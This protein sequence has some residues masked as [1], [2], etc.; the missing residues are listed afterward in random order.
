MVGELHRGRDESAGRRAG[1]VWVGVGM[2]GFPR[3]REFTG[4]MWGPELW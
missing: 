1:G 3:A 4:A 2:L